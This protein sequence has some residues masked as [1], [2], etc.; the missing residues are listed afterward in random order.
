MSADG[1]GAGNN[2]GSGFSQVGGV[3]HLLEKNYA[4]LT[5]LGR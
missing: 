4:F 3:K 5:I 1:G 2:W